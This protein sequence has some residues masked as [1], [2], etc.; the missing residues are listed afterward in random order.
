MMDEAQRRIFL[1][2]E[3]ENIATELACLVRRQRRLY[4]EIERDC[5]CNDGAA[6]PPRKKTANTSLP[7]A[8]A[9]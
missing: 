5:R 4:V 2:N 3:C 9:S 8:V 1:T 6:W 7:M